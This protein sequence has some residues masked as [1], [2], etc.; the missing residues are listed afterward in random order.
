[1]PNNELKQRIQMHQDVIAELNVLSPEVEAYNMRIG[2]F[3]LKNPRLAGLPYSGV[4]ILMTE[5][6]SEVAYRAIKVVSEELRTRRDPDTPGY[7]LKYRVLTDSR[8]RKIILECRPSKETTEIRSKPNQIAINVRCPNCEAQIRYVPEKRGEVVSFRATQI[9]DNAISYLSTAL[10][11][12]RSLLVNA[13]LKVEQK[14]GRSLKS[15]L[16]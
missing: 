13:L 9:T 2:Q 11:I 12:S 7:R 14:N 4:E 5:K 8:V 16:K 3:V 1:M 6:D 10:G 15:S